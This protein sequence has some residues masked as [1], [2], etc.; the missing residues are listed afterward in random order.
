MLISSCFLM[1]ASQTVEPNRP[2]VELPVVDPA[3]GRADHCEVAVNDQRDFLVVWQTEYDPI[4]AP[5]QLR[6]EGI[7]GAYDPVEENWEL[8]Q[9]VIL[10]EP[11]H[12]EDRCHKADVIAIDSNDFAV[13]WARLDHHGPDR[14][15][16]VLVRD[17]EPGSP[18]PVIVRPALGQG[19]IVDDGLEGE[20][21]GILP[22]LVWTEL[23]GDDEFA[24]VYNNVTADDPGPPHH[25]EGEIRW[26]HV[27]P[28]GASWSAQA[29]VLVPSIPID[30]VMA[31]TLQGSRGVVDALF[32][33]GDRFCLAWEQAEYVSGSK[34]RSSVQL[35]LC[36]Y[37]QVGPPSVL[38][39][40]SFQAGVGEFA[41]LIRRPKL[42]RSPL[43]DGPEIA[44]ACFDV[45]IG[46]EQ[47]TYTW[48]P[49]ILAWE[50]N[51]ETGDLFALPVP[52]LGEQSRLLP[53][54]V[55][56]LDTRALFF[57][58]YQ[59]GHPVQQLGEIH[60]SRSDLGQKPGEAL[61]T[62]HGRS[63]SVALHESTTR[64]DTLVIASQVRF[65][66]RE[67]SRIQVSVRLGDF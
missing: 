5:G 65:S 24:I 23:M 36:D 9:P 45:R 42:M 25:I 49:G 4:G 50:V 18:D 31:D 7:Y 66:I 8:S 55:T 62:I 57:S 28:N 43:E 15:E 67:E 60:W 41:R 39:S 1:L 30:G 33:E 10:G 26:A 27:K 38:R 12:A 37:K 17:A 48:S 21:L 51:L 32:I 3:S 13:T 52:I 53:V 40:Y 46:Q 22:E 59:P 16:A 2:P 58:W 44:V 34:Y 6:V 19:Y 56:T 54:P 63:P 47:G 14:V 61:S 20:P 64:L 35:R 11:L 29:E